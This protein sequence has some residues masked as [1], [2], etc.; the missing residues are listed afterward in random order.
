MTKINES[1]IWSADRIWTMCNKHEYYT[2]GY[3]EDYSK[4]LNFVTN[5]K[6]TTNN[7]YKVAMDIFEHSDINLDH[8]GVDKDEMI[9]AIM[10]DIHNEC[11]SVHYEINRVA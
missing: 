6:P 10:F 4:M 7:I 5:H 3:N 8:Y 2:R 1:K 9:Q 11:V